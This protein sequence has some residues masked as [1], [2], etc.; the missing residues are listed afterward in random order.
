MEPRMGERRSERGSENG[1]GGFGV[2]GQGR[3]SSASAFRLFVR[4]A[5]SDLAIAWRW[6]SSRG[7]SVAA[8]LALADRAS[9]W[10]RRLRGA[11]ARGAGLFRGR[12]QGRRAEVLPGDLQAAPLAGHDS[13]PT[14]SAPR[15]RR[16]RMA[17]V[18]AALAG[19]AGAA[20]LVSLGLLAWALWGMDFAG[21]A[22][23]ERSPTIVVETIEGETFASKGSFKGTPVALDRMP[24]H[25]IDAVVA[26]EDRRF[27][28]HPGVDV[29]GV[30]RA[31][32]ANVAAG[33]IVQGGSTISQQLARSLFLTQDRTLRRKLREAALAVWLEARLTKEQ[34]L[35]RYLGSIYMGT[36]V[37]GMPAAAKVYF[38]KEPMDLTLA[39][40]AVLAGLI[41][42]PSD[43]NPRADLE[44]ARARAAVVLDNMVDAGVIDAAEVE[45]A[46]AAPAELN[47]A[48]V[49]LRSG[50]WFADWIYGEATELAGSFNGALYV[51]STL[52]PRVQAL[53]EQAVRDVLDAEGATANA[54]EAALVMM[55]ADGAVLAMVG[56][57]DYQASQFN[58]ATDALR[59]PGSTFK[60][61]VYYAA[62]RQGW[63][64]GDRIDDA[65]IEVGGWAPKNYGGR[66]AGRVNLARALASSLNAATVRLAQEVGIDNV[67]AAAREL[68]IDARLNPTPSLAL[69]TSEVTLLDLTGAYASIVA[70]KAPVEP[71]GI[72]DFGAASDDR[73]RLGPRTPAEPIP[74]E[75]RA[76]MLHALVMAVEEGTGR[77]AKL[78]RPVAGKTG[79]TQDHR[80]AWFVGFTGPFIAGVWVG[81]D[82]NSPMDGVTG[83]QL[84]AKIWR[85]FMTGFMDLLADGDP[86]FQGVSA[87][88][89]AAASQT[90]PAP[91]GFSSPRAL[92]G[93][94]RGQWGGGRELACNVNACERAYR[95][96]RRS[97][98][99]FQPYSGPRK[100]CAK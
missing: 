57:R 27:F 15:R 53:A 21:I 96:F 90:V 91:D 9:R 17:A 74:P 100:R 84:P 43:L 59:Q 8:R 94:A 70:G 41:K 72:L 1:S 40:A 22:E 49:A 77:A 78:D 34:I 14:A 19:A 99:T 16:S 56:G 28:A 48:A 6:L 39:E 66:F 33:D 85:A 79:T 36:G 80:D 81:N 89:T 46:K 68:G 61:F 25:L 51:R 23:N 45:A 92:P 86:V 32:F 97:D 88:Q 42:A 60:P 95:S 5:L 76:E 50:G 47:Q 38:G 54:S 87:R 65:P 37:Y 52:H 63:S 73:Y 2:D 83:G 35:A 55:L 7:R 4:A 98:C 11:A 44:A 82:D 30:A 24:Q 12:A 13:P 67:A 58:R 3:L 18:A 69:G 64:M 71:W 93:T 20:A 31:L 29:I 26:T 10:A 75:L 62:L